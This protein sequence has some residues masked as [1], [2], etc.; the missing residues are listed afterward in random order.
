MRKLASIRRRFT[1]GCSQKDNRLA[2]A[3]TPLA[4]A[5]GR[6]PSP[7]EAYLELVGGTVLSDQP[8]DDEGDDITRDP[9]VDG[10]S[11]VSTETGNSTP[12]RL[13]CLSPTN[14]TSALAASYIS[15]DTRPNT[16]RDV[17]ASAESRRARDSR[18]RV[19]MVHDVPG[20]ASRTDQYAWCYEVSRV[21]RQGGGRGDAGSGRQHAPSVE[22]LSEGSQ[23]H[24]SQRPGRAEN[25]AT[26]ARALTRRRGD[27]EGAESPGSLLNSAS[28]AALAGGNDADSS[29]MLVAPVPTPPPRARAEPVECIICFD[30]FLAPT[31]RGRPPAFGCGHTGHSDQICAGCCAKVATCPLCRAPRIAS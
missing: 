12:T 5:G 25:A 24:A 28:A 21:Q 3:D 11:T 8:S 16:Q 31:C 4:G 17:P 26:A 18:Q 2:V 19:R 27:T 23:V 13:P 29:Y 9:T 22:Q 7:T 14:S 15:A 10:G 6:D 20:W 1:A 30:M